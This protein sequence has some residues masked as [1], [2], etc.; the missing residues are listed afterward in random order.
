M[1]WCVS[2]PQIHTLLHCSGPEPAQVLKQISHP[3]LWH[4]RS[5]PSTFYGCWDGPEHAA[6]WLDPSSSWQNKA[7]PCK[8]EAGTIEAECGQER[9]Q[10]SAA[11]VH[12]LGD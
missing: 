1:P 3:N 5:I 4:L 7:D 8:P 9:L 6:C 11:R 12:G 10:N 2:L